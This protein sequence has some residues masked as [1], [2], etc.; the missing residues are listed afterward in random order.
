MG[1]SLER[2]AY[3]LSVITLV[4]V[5]ATLAAWL[6]LHPLA[7]FWRRAG[8]GKSVAAITF[9]V[10]GTMWGMYL[11][12][13]PLLRVGFGMRSSLVGASGVLLAMSFYMNVLVYRVTPK[14]M[15]LGLAELGVGDGGRLVTSGIYSR[16]RHPRFVAMFLAVTA[17]A[18]FANRLALY[19]LSATYAAVIW[20]V[21]VL[22]ESE[23]RVRFGALYDAY[24]DK[25]PRFLPRLARLDL[26]SG[27][28]AT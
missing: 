9:V 11:V 24:R 18:L 25:V 2:V 21:A 13:E 26:G 1:V 14:A 6:V 22:E 3:Y 27:R 8:V 7:A 10:L 20:I 15:A 16:M 23:L 12:R 17:V 28:D 19:A 5:P 4:T